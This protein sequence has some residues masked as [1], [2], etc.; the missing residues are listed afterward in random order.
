MTDLNYFDSFFSNY[1][2]KLKNN[3][4]KDQNKEKNELIESQLDYSKVRYSSV[5]MQF[6]LYFIAT[7]LLIGFIFIITSSG[8]LSF[9]IMLILVIIL[10]IIIKYLNFNIINFIMNFKLK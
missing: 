10:F 3:D 2:S 5:H 7:F 4:N 6:I 1:F 8:K 9:Y